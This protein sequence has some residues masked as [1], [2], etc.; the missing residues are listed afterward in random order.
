MRISAIRKA[1]AFVWRDFLNEVSYRFG[2]FLQFGG[3]FVSAL[4]WCVISQA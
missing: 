3:A 2:F 4:T 1:L